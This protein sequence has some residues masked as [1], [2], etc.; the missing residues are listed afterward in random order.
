MFRFSAFRTRCS[1]LRSRL[2]ALAVLAVMA[3]GGSASMPSTLEAQQPQEL[4]RQLNRSGPRF[5]VTFLS[6]SITEKLQTD[7]N[8][9]VAPVITQ[10]GW[11]FERQF[12]SLENGPVALNEWVLLVGGLDQGAFLPSLTW[13]VGIR[14]PGNFEIGVGPNATPAGVALALSTGYTFKVGALAVPINM[15]IVPSKYGVRASVLTGFNMY[16]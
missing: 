9:E 4:V 11:Q 13:L 5:G 2:S 12:A 14:T 10:F 6:G 15:A 1:A 7:Y 8:I 3:L 16:K